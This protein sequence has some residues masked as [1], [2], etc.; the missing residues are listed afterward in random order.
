M[1]RLAI[2]PGDKHVGWCHD[3]F[4]ELEA[5][6]WS[7]EASIAEIMRLLEENTVDEVVLEEFALYPWENHRQALSRMLTPQLI[8]QIKLVAG[9]HGVEVVEQQASIKKPTRAQLR[10]RGIKQ[11]GKGPHAKDAELHYYY[12]KLREDG[13]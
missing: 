4:R 5:G 3:L 13:D 2:D 12:R 1:K 10:G 9:E 7:N 11:I 6:E 8:G